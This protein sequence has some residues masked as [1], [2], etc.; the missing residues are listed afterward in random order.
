MLPY[1]NTI[2]FCS[3]W[4]RLFSNLETGLRKSK[5]I[6]IKQHLIIIT[7][8]FSLQ[9]CKFSRYLLE[10]LLKWIYLG[11]SKSKQTRRKMK[12]KLPKTTVTKADRGNPTVIIKINDY[13]NS[14]IYFINSNGY[15]RLPTNLLSKYQTQKRKPIN[16]QQ[17]TNQTSALIIPPK[18]KT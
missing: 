14:T 11:K 18:F 16:F 12:N 10:R 13:T 8:I 15:I 3:G 7:V 4:F 6:V 5:N 1:H 9:S 17:T 2:L